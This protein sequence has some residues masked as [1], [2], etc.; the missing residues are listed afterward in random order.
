MANYQ[1]SAAYDL[2]TF[3]DRS[4]RAVK[5]NVVN[6][7]E[8]Q[9]KKAVRANAA[10]VLAGFVLFTGIFAANVLAYTQITETTAQVNRLSNQLTALQNEGKTLSIQ[11]DEMI[12][13]RTVEQMAIYTYGMNKLTPNQMEYVSVKNQDKTEMLADT[14]FDFN[15][16]FPSTM[17]KLSAFFEYF[18]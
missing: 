4:R 12:D 2:T 11:Y 18:S 10:K 5:Q 8:K 9:R 1:S 6:V 7:V 15:Q 13:L 3:D 17:R 14:G 16:I